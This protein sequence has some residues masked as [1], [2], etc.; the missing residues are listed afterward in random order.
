MMVASILLAIAGSMFVTVVKATTASDDARDAAT[1][2]G[3]AANS[4]GR[5]IR[6]A[7]QLPKA[8]QTALD[9]AVMAGT[10]SSITVSSLVMSASSTTLTPVKIRYS[11]VNGALVEETWTGSNSTG[12]WLFTGTASRTKNLGSTIVLPTGAQAPIFTYLDG[13]GNPLVVAAGGLT[14]AQRA[15][16]GSVRLTLRVRSATS[17]RAKPI[18]I[19]TTI[20]MPNLG[21]SGDG[22]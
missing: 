21:Y 17:T 1:V 15:V 11:I 12:Y 5:A 20:G 2:A 9:A 18:I 16:V 10:G 19:D 14:D 8:N 4:I 7:V 13:T 22:D 3:T 6:S